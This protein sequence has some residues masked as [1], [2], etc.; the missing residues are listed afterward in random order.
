MEVVY[1][2]RCA[3]VVQDGWEAVDRKEEVFGETDDIL[4]SIPVRFWGD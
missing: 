4:G 1:S 3:F 2:E